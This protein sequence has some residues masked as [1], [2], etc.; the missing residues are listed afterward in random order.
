[1][2]PAFGAVAPAEPERTRLPAAARPVVLVAGNPNSG[3]STL[4]NA[5][6]S[7]QAEAANYAFCTIE[8]NVGVVPV[9]DRRFDAASS[10]ETDGLC[11]GRS[12]RPMALR[13]PSRAS[14][15]MRPARSIPPKTIADGRE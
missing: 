10:F 12:H 9:P 2:T 14:I 1:M 5:L 13:R 8:P 6:S 4:F 15:R 3:K 11:H 7:K